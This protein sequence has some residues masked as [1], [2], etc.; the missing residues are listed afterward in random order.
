MSTGT[1][2][3]VMDRIRGASIDSPIAV[4]SVG[5]SEK[6]NAVFGATITTQRMIN[7]QHP[8]LIGVYNNQMNMDEVR[9]QLNSHLISQ[10]RKQ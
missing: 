2:A 7:Q 4:F 8:D 6:L 9:K 10:G 1:L 3:Q 5:S